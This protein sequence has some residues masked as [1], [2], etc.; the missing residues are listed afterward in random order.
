[1]KISQKII[2]KELSE[3][4]KELLNDFRKKR[5]FSYNNYLKDKKSIINKYF[6]ENNIDTAVIA[7]SGGVDSSL[8]LAIICS[9]QKELD[10]PIKNII[11]VF[12]PCHSKAATNQDTAYEKC[13]NLVANFGLSL[14]KIDITNLHKDISKS[15]QNDL[16]LVADNWADG[17][18]VSYFRTTAL[19]YTTSLL[20]A[21]GYRPVV[22]G[23]TN[24]DEGA[25]TGYFGKASD[26]MVDLQI[27]SDIHKSEVLELAKRLNVSDKVI[28][29]LPTGDMYD[30]RLDEDVF[31]APYDFVELHYY[32]KQLSKSDFDNFKKSLNKES[33]YLFDIMWS[34]IENMHRYN[35]HKYY[36]CSPA[37]HLDVIESS[38]KGGWK[39]STY[40]NVIGNT[41]YGDHKTW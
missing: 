4:L 8:V 40:D 6:L 5:N 14:Q 13:K 41:I 16:N 27:I 3:Q 15:I 24:K 1:M 18:L 38:A 20:T 33:L 36:G 9:A 11:P 28:K 19:Y 23:T 25:Y 7:V 34:N 37:V 2:I 35:K 31:G 30:G 21:N 26:G 22:V 12:M 32:L 39:Y 10:S 17:Q 29:A